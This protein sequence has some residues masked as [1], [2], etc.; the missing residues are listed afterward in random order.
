MTTNL[1]HILSDQ[2]GRTIGLW[3]Y[4][5][6]SYSHDELADLDLLALFGRVALLGDPPIEAQNEHQ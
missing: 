4:L 2:V 6:F 1:M 5:N 3:L